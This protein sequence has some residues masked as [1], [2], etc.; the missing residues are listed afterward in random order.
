MRISLGIFLLLVSIDMSAQ[1]QG[2]VNYKHLGIAFEIPGGWVGQQTDNGL[3]MGSYTEPG[4]LIFS[5]GEYQTETRLFQE[6]QNSYAD[7]N[8]T[9][10]FLVHPPVRIRENV[11]EVEMAGTIQWEPAKAYGIVQLNPL[12]K[13]PSFLYIT[14]PEQFTSENRRIVNKIHG[15]LKL[16][17]PETGELTNQWKEFLSNVRLTYLDSY[18]SGPSTAGGAYVGGSSKTE[19]DL[20]PQGYFLFN[21]SSQVVGGSA[22]ASLG[23][24]NGNNGHGQWQVDVGVSGNAVLRLQFYTGENREYVITGQDNSGEVIYLDNAKYFRTRGGQYA[25]RCN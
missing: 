19:I 23:S 6:L 1:I 5:L 18:Y 9:R 17:R 2:P 13:D 14:S 3:T 11:Y 22:G 16:F 7:E 15:S 4:M 25:A 24:S 12:G 21:S 8:G 20:C 10:L